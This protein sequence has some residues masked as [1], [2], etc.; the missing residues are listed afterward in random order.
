MFIHSL[1]EDTAS[2]YENKN[3][4]AVS[5]NDEKIDYE[6]LDSLANQM[7]RALI[8][9]GVR[10]GD[11][12]GVCLKKSI[13][14]V[15]A[16]L[17]I[18]KAG[19]V[20][21]PLDPSYPQARLLYMGEHAGIKKLFLNKE[22]STLFHECSFDLL[23][24]ENLFLSHYSTKKP[25]VEIIDSGAYV[26]YTS[27]TTGNPKGI[28]MG[29]RALLNLIHWQNRETKLGPQNITLQFAPLS[30]DVHFQEIF[31]T[32]TTGGELVLIE[33]EKRR[34]P[35]GLLKTI[36]EKK[37]N[38]LFMPYVALRQMCEVGCSFNII[39]KCLKE[40]T[41]AGEQLKITNSIRSFFNKI[42]DCI[43]YNHYGPS[44]TH[45]VT[46]FAL[47]G[48]ADKWPGLPPIGKN[49]D[50]AMLSIVDSQNCVV[51]LGVSG[52]IVIS[53]SCLSDGYLN[54][55][56]ETEKKFIM[57]D[58]L[59]RC[60]KTGDQGY[61]DN[62]GNVHFIGRGDSQVKIS[63]Y[64]VECVE[65]EL[66]LI[67]KTSIRELIVKVVSEDESSETSERSLCA[68][69]VSSE[70]SLKRNDFT[71]ILPDYM[72]PSFF[73][74]VESLPLTPSGKVD[75][76]K[77]PSP[78]S[79][80]PDYLPE[81]SAP[82]GELE[83]ELVKSWI[84]VLNNPLI[85]RDDN[86]FDIGGNSLMAIK[87]L[88]DFNLNH[89]MTIKVTDFFQYPTVESLAK[90]LGNK[91]KKFTHGSHNKENIRN[92]K[93]HDIA[94]IAMIGRFP[95]AKSPDELFENCLNKKNSISESTYRE[96][97]CFDYKYFNMTP[98]EAELMDPQQ[99]K[100]LELGHEVLELAG[101]QPE[102]FDGLIGI[103][104]GM[105]NSKYGSLVAN[106]PEKVLR[107]GEFNV[108]LGLEKDYIATR[109]AYKL[110]LKGPALSIHTGCSTTLVAI[111]EAAKA[112]RNF[113]CDLAIA[114][115]IS[116]YAQ[117]DNSQFVEGGIFSKDGNCAP[118]D[119]NA[120][121]TIFT[122]GAGLVVL[123]R[124][125]DAVQ[126]NDTIIAVIKGVGINND[127]ADK[128]SFTAPSSNG[129]G[130]VILQA[131]QDANVLPDSIGYI[132]AHG[133]ATPLGD[134][135][136]LQ[137]LNEA[138]KL[139]SSN[140][141]NKKYCY[142]SS[143]KSH[144]GHLTAAA[145]VASFIKSCLVVKK[146]IIPGTLH[147]RE[148]HPNLNLKDMPFIITSE[149]SEFPV[150]H[151][152]RRAGVSSFGVGGT[153]A[154]VIIENYTPVHLNQIDNLNSLSLFKLSAKNPELLKLSKNNLFNFLSNAPECDFK[155]I[156]YTLDIGRKEQAFRS[157]IIAKNNDVDSFFSN[158][159]QDKFSTKKLCFLFPGQSSQY[160]QMGINLYLTNALF[161]S[162][163][164]HCQEI[165]AIL[166]NLNIKEILFSTDSQL[167]NETRYSQ[168][169]LFFIEYSLGM[170]LLNLGFK[171]DYL[172]GHSIG[173]FAAAAI[174]GVFTLKDAIHC[175]LKRS[176]LISKLSEG[177]MLSVL[178][179]AQHLGPYL[180][181]FDL[182]I[183]AY[184]GTCSTVVSGESSTLLALKAK[185]LEACVPCI[186]LSA[187][188]AFHSRMMN[189][190]SDEFLEF[191]QNIHLSN[192]NLPILSTVTGRKE[193]EIFTTA[194]YW[195]KH[196]VAPVHF[197]DAVH[198]L[199]KYDATDSET[200]FLEIGPK[201]TLIN[202]LRKELSAK[203]FC[204]FAVL[205]NH[206]D[207]EELTF[208]KAIGLLWLH[209]HKVQDLGLLYSVEEQK[210]VPAPTTIFEKH[211]LWVIPEKKP[212]EKE[213]NMTIKNENLAETEQM[214]Q[215]SDQLATLLEKSSGIEVSQF[216]YKTS[217]LEMGMDSLFL[218]QVSIIL[219]KEYKVAVN[220]R[221]LI[222][223][224]SSIDLL[225][226]FLMPKLHLPKNETIK[227]QI[228]DVNE[229]VVTK[230]NQLE[231]A[232]KQ[233]IEKQ[234]QIMADQIRLLRGDYAQVIQPTDQRL[235]EKKM[236]E[237]FGA[238]AR[239]TLE[240][241]D[242]LNDKQKE[243][244]RKFQN[245]YNELT[246]SSKLFTQ[247]NRRNHADP[248]AVSGFKPEFKEFVYPIVV[249][250]SQGQ[251]LWDLDDNKYIDMTCGFGSNFFG[252]G[253][254][255]I[256]KLIHEQL[257]YGVE[258][259]PQHPLVG[260]VSSLICELTGN[261][262]TAFCNTGSE[263]V[264]GALRMARTVTGKDKVIVFSGSYH[265]I[266]DEVILRASKEGMAI[267]AA[268]GIPDSAVANMI[269]L[270]YG[271]EES[272]KY[273]REHAHEV[274]AI[275]VE[276]VQSRRCNF[277][278]IEFLREVRTI[279]GNKNCCL[280][281]DEIIT[282]FRIHPAGAQGYFGIRADICT[283][284]KIIGGGMPIGVISGKTEYLDSL[285]GG[286]WEFGDNSTPTTGVTY[287]AGTFV[288][289]PLALAAAYG[290]LSIIKESG[291]KRFEE[292]NAESQRFVD[293]LNL[294]LLIEKIPLEMNNFGSLMKPKWT[295]EVQGGELL[296]AALRFYGV[297][298][299]DGFPW[300]INLCHTKE[301][302]L[303]VLSAFKK[304]VKLLQRMEL[305][306]KVIKEKELLEEPPLL[307]AK[308]GRDEQGNPA[309][310]IE[311]PKKAGEYFLL[312]G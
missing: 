74:K 86:F 207:N 229:F 202:L 239:I 113:D 236:K 164:D 39:P 151:D 188:H 262:R 241:T 75:L 98:R 287:F 11:I 21:L 35:L 96:Q 222:E 183:A 10:P 173:E 211:R 190:A 193:N 63:G 105:G 302:L 58:K 225:A 3:A 126:D 300:F 62:D 31:S 175:V 182:D 214:Q 38:R 108:M 292:L 310:F 36:S 89:I 112:L 146:G 186:E 124:L 224:H 203:K 56:S 230:T 18:L 305:F 260:V 154:H 195:A 7:C 64:R 53:G 282:G 170:T 77:L 273:I 87:V 147:F 307:G 245:E 217:F 155:K 289:H 59:G 4:I 80:R 240:R 132:E 48:N 49:I 17:A 23:E 45:V 276:P 184:N 247:T 204:G 277:H 243:N 200:L 119:M 206:S 169:G 12:V 79:V 16:L 213:K 41:T 27:G 284:G 197:K 259:G 94:V 130:Q 238:Q 279:T 144:I 123:K 304:A 306:P 8:D 121:G 125:S 101:Y 296:Y 266:I 43:L 293:E 139:E 93:Y 158:D 237:A 19:A 208:T 82:Q 107:A 117:A 267:P 57:I 61:F 1:F 162:H 163:F 114:G 141:V 161:R 263:A 9:D 196:L 280:I 33:D 20:Y 257:E 148:A 149:N 134:P 312:E 91:N 131:L 215:L 99:R 14:M 172:I 83:K 248:R 233:V 268:P 205:G 100:L 165:A 199:E 2:L 274:A 55:E 176:E 294:F 291:E 269:V 37:I 254:E 30:F 309:W 275:L 92:E 255:K 47:Y 24:I 97:D 142:I 232:T 120:S 249:K 111:I 103:Y 156:A 5:F 218:T 166:T 90:F 109:L 160:S 22:F 265:G 69:Y 297:H 6:T 290:A 44:E 187:T 278:P 167:L 78:T 76:K 13:E 283:Y 177:K 34:D 227:T 192:P 152:T 288:R 153:N 135:I 234:L 185:L 145:G 68:Y 253:N 67:S 179:S 221:Q 143:L 85:G 168:P 60:Y 88:S 298:T 140:D 106:C 308:I 299:Y 226:K 115:G 212:L 180:Q 270:D 42:D 157:F 246:N 127:G 272:L 159:L 250:K 178:M 256:K 65:V 252:N 110:N 122:E 28:L 73:I 51:N 26:I 286:Y 84:K 72:I 235:P 285:D 104:A 191:M 281:F 261:D 271:T 129:Q 32:L 198:F 95:G 244:I 50:G 54:S 150:L 228:S 181:E 216:D 70:Y 258:L 223:E 201:S 133:T 171:P 219:K 210:R 29:H 137:A 136:E 138:F 231:D 40:V 81:F 25:F 301:D 71:D 303:F 116:I 118:F 46:S 220:F 15:A 194:A 242:A 66:A 251:Y 209:G 128:M 295:R 264:L 52:E 311:N 189:K 102:S 174:A